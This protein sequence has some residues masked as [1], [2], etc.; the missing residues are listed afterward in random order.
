MTDRPVELD[1]T[2]RSVVV[3][4]LAGSFWLGWICFTLGAWGVVFFDRILTLWVAS[5]AMFIVIAAV[6]GP[7][8]LLRPHHL[9]LLLPSLWLATA[10]LIPSANL[11]DGGPWLW[12]TV[13]MTLVGLPYLCAFLIQ[14]LTPGY[15]E[16]RR[17]RNL[18]IVATAVFVIAVLSFGVGRFNNRIFTCE[19]FRVSGNALPPTCQPNGS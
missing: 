11:D 17:H 18:L 3:A 9:A 10:F 1:P 14:M 16:L 7:R 15:G 5:L 8:N 2:L 19:D 6:G 13:A 12:L 4:T